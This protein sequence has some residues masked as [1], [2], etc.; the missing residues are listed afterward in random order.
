MVSDRQ[1][2]RRSLQLYRSDFEAE[3]AFKKVMLSL[4]VYPNCFERS[5]KH[6]HFTGS[7]WVV[8]YSFD[9]ALL[10]HHAQLDKW[11]QLGGHADGLE[12]M[13]KVATKELQ[14]E[15]GLKSF[16]LETQE[17]FDLDIH[18]IPERKGVPEHAHYDIR[19]LFVADEQEKVLKNHE[20]KALA[21]VP[22]PAI[23]G[24]CNG[25]D[26]IMRM[27]EKTNVLRSKMSA[28]V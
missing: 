15:S 25:N 1:R 6:A 8:N 5:L 20:S 9:K 12:D 22:L 26:S 13:C 24:L 3:L 18:T 7:A 16:R 28:K 4:L 2:F 27:I 23:A 21:W 19:Y 17:I 11:L 14:E 10:T